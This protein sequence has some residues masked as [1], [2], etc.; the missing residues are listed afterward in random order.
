MSTTPSSSYDDG[1]V[2]VEPHSRG[3][4]VYLV[5]TERG[6]RARIGIYTARYAALRRATALIDP[7]RPDGPLSA[8]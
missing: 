3:W 2:V 6:T 1:R 4:A 8:Y 5:D 7:D